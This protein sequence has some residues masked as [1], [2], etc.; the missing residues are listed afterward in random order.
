MTAPDTGETTVFVE[1]RQYEQAL[2]RAGRRLQSLGQ[3]LEQD[4]K[5]V[6]ARGFPIQTAVSGARPLE[7]DLDELRNMFDPQAAQ[8]VGRLLAEY[9]HLLA[10]DIAAS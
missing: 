5:R 8:N 9:Q 1:K 4:P 10:L 3:L 6:V 2:M 7:L